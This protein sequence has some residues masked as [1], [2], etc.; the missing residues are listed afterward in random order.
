MTGDRYISNMSYFKLSNISV[1]NYS[2]KRW[3]FYWNNA[4]KC[5]VNFHMKQRQKR[6]TIHSQRFL[7]GENIC[8]RNSLFID[9]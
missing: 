5:L 4:V 6:K 1:N 3:I 9:F 7:D 2:T 8:L